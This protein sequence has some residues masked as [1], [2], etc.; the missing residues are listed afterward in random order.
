MS[1]QRDDHLGK[2]LH[3]PSPSGITSES[4]GKRARPNMTITRQ[5]WPS[6]PAQLL[7]KPPALV[8]APAQTLG[9]RNISD[10]F[11]ESDV[12]SISGEEYSQLFDEP[13]RPSAGPSVEQSVSGS[14]AILTPLPSS[15]SLEDVSSADVSKEKEV[16]VD[17][18]QHNHP[19]VV[20][21][22]TAAK[23]ASFVVR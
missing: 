2:R 3:S 20:D 12:S 22:E 17:I 1:L 19:S 9:K 13:R 10:A 23:P 21:T 5:I 4:P 8:P 18:A 16:K 7:P 6:R 14:L 15:A 11:S